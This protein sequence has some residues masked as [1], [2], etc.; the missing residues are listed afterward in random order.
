MVRGAG[1][2]VSAEGSGAHYHENQGDDEQ[3]DGDRDNMLDPAYR[4]LYPAVRLQ[5]RSRRLP[6]RRGRADRGLGGRPGAGLEVSLRL[7]GGPDVRL[8]T[9]GGR[10][11]PVERGQAD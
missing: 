2:A 8:D 1:R 7:E 4:D 3:D 6:G 9:R 11:N 10:L 5:G